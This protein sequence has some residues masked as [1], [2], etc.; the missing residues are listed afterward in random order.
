MS[1]SSW[2]PTPSGWGLNLDVDHVAF[3]GR[4]KFDGRV[5]RMLTPG[6]TGQIAGRAGRYMND[7]TFGVSGECDPFDADLIEKLENHDFEPV[8]IL[9]WRNPDLDFS[10]IAALQ[11]SL[12]EMPASARL[13]RTRENDD[14]AVLE[15]LAGDQEI[16]DLTSTRD[17]VARLWDA[18]Q[19]PDYQKISQAS[20]AE[21]VANLYR[22]LVSGDG[23]I[24]EDWIEKQVRQAASTEGDIDTLA[25]RISLIRT[26]TFVSNREGWLADPEHWQSPHPRD[27]GQPFGRACTSNSR[28]A[29]ST[30]APAS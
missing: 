30:G 25:N 14:V 7:G 18:C 17:A 8:K 9:Q 1:I 10:S 15:R 11:A 27:R 5:H 20:H 2:P 23:M 28:S 6:E 12:N 26:W 24:P 4:R 16:A 21:L 3:A 13:Q 29:L 19:V 22:F